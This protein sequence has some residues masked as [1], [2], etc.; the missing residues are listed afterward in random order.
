MSYSLVIR[1]ILSF[2]FDCMLALL[3]S[4]PHTLPTLWKSFI[5]CPV[6][7]YVPLSTTECFKSKRFF[8]ATAVV[9]NLKTE[10]L[11]KYIESLRV[12][13]CLSEGPK[14]VA[15]LSKTRTQKGKIQKGFY[16]HNPPSLHGQWGIETGS[17][18]ATANL[19]FP[20]AEKCNNI[21]VNDFFKKSII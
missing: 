1:N 19:L 9:A 18:N 8:F 3:V 7:E 16:T 6:G 20:K 17:I 10:T 2:L 12:F 11:Y 5:Y 21:H 15:G 14:N 4:I 13:V